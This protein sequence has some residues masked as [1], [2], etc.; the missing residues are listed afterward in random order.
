MGR[1][2]TRAHPGGG[3]T[4]R[5]SALLNLSGIAKAWMM[6]GFLPKTPFR[7]ESH[8]RWRSTPSTCP[9]LPSP[10]AASATSLPS[11]HLERVEMHRRKFAASG[12]AARK[13]AEPQPPACSRGKDT[14]SGGTGGQARTSLGHVTGSNAKLARGHAPLLIFS[15][16]A[17][18]S[19]IE[20]RRGARRAWVALA[21]PHA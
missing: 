21:S 1:L 20:K 13:I 8:R 7:P 5:C 11:T 4:T 14:W 9:Y 16:A 12:A 17:R 6:N 10:S 19:L 2:E 18:P 3:R 15:C